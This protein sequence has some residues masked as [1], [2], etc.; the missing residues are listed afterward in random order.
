MKIVILVGHTKSGT[1]FLD[2]AVRSSGRIAVLGSNEV[3]AMS[4]AAMQH[5]A[6]ITPVYAYHQNAVNV[7]E[8]MEKLKNFA[9]DGPV[10]IVYRNPIDA[11]LSLVRQMMHGETG[12]FDAG[13]TRSVVF[14]SHPLKDIPKSFQDGPFREV[15]KDRYDYVRSA[16]IVRENFPLERIKEYVFE[17][18][19]S[20]STRIMADLSEAL[21]EEITAPGGPV[22]V[23]YTARS[24]TLYH[25]M[26]AAFVR[27][28]G[29]DSSLIRRAAVSGT[30]RGLLP[31]LYRLNQRSPDTLL[32]ARQR[33]VILETLSFDI[34]AFNKL[35]GLNPNWN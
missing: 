20:D 4:P 29:L 22:N 26:N 7:P 3:E 12:S 15:V 2:T 21:G 25:L 31:R 6:E 27:V 14:G 17:E 13:L 1:A 8:Y 33:Q 19:V 28:T 5:K 23:S 11:A 30:K 18:F 24:R 34:S 32:T 35:T 9:A 16:R 10:F